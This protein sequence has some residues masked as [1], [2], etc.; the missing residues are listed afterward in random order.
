MK[1]E[2]AT[3]NEILRGLVGSTAHGINIVGQDDRDETGV[4]IEPPASD[5]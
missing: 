4:F 3:K 5:G 1:S 2:I